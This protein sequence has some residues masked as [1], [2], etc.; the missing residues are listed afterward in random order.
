MELARHRVAK[1][2]S[3]LATLLAD[4]DHVTVVGVT[5]LAAD[6]HVPV[7]LD[8]RC[9]HVILPPPFIEQCQLPCCPPEMSGAF[10]FWEVC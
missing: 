3:E 10:S 2:P 8:W 4:Y 1:Y 6:G 9:H 7:F 5:L